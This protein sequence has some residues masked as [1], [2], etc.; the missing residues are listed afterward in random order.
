VDDRERDFGLRHFREGALDRLERALHVGLEHDLELLGLALFDLREHLVE[1][2]GPFRRGTCGALACV[3]RDN[4]SGGLLVGDDAHDVAGLG[5]LGETE[6]F[7]R[8]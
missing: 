5:N 1:G 2:R 7:D 6:D 3:L 8:A 4:G